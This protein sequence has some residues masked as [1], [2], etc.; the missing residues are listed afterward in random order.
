M[1]PSAAK[2]PKSS[3]VSKTKAR[4][5]HEALRS[6][7][8]P[9]GT[10]VPTH[11]LCCR[12][13]GRE[14]EVEVSSAALTPEACTCGACGGALF[15]SADEPM[16]ALPAAAYGHP[17]DA[18]SLSAL[19]SVPGFDRAVKWTMEQLLDRSMRLQLM[20]SSIRCGEDQL[21]ELHAL[22]ERARHRLG[23]EWPA[24]LYVTQSPLLNAFTAGVEERVVVVYSS[25]VSELDDAALLALF[26]H[27]LGHQHAEHGLYRTV[28]AL[29]MTGGSLIGP[30]R[31]FSL[32]LQLA[33]YK[34]SRCAEL[35][36]DRAGF[37][38]SRDLGASIR[39]LVALTAGTAT[40]AGSTTRE[41]SPVALAAF[42]RQARDLAKMEGASVMDGLVAALL[43]MRQ[44]HPFPA[45]RLMHLLQWVESGA[46]LELLAGGWP[47]APARR[48]REGRTAA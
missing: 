24:V 43:T 35:P 37:L 40:A 9:E 26:G 29:L 18:R 47:G 20:G 39:L 31:L 33:M 1:S 44:S 6:A 19:K 14:N 36:C 41:R 12:H 21:P 7:L 27:E 34:W 25:M 38:A 28:A 17:L 4:A 13:C 5:D 48:G 3:K 10:P 23:L 2:T 30:L 11:D 8:W 42:V 32:P 15:L 45:W 46:Y 16:T 22:L